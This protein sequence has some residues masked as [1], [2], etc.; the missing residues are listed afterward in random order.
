MVER[1]RITVKAAGVGGVVE[2]VVG[3]VEEAEVIPLLGVVE[4]L[5][6]ILRGN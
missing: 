3:A 4:F 6:K 1:R 5:I 2:E